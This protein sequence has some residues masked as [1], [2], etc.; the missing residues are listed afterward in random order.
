MPEELR[1]HDSRVLTPRAV[2]ITF[3]AMAAQPGD[4]VDM[5]SSSRWSGLLKGS[6]YMVEVPANWNGKLVMYAHE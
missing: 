4:T 6:A 3:A 2:S 1:A 5:A